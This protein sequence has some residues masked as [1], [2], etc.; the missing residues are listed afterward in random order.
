M[1][2]VPTL[3]ARCAP[4]FQRHPSLRTAILFGS[5]ARGTRNGSSDVDVAVVGEGTDVLGLSA[6]LARVLQCEVDVVEVNDQSSIPLLRAIIQDG[7]TL[8]ERGHGE[9]TEFRRRALTV[10]DLDGPGYDRMMTRFL[11]RVAR[12]GVGP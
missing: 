10:L 5:T 6:E 2:D 11:A 12:R 4:L 7:H 1:R 9:A 8:Y 3:K